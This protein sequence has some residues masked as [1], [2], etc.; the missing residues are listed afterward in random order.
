MQR[1]L[2]LGVSFALVVE[3]GAI[4]SP[5]PETV[6]TQFYEWWVQNQDQGRQR[7]SQQRA[8]FT[9]ELYQQLMQAFRKQPRDG[10]WLDFDPFSFTQV[11]TQ[12]VKV[13]SVRRSPN[14][15]RVAEVDIE[16]MAGLR[17]RS[18]TTVPMKGLLRQGGDRWQI[19]NLIYLNTWDNLRCLLR[20]IN[21]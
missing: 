19:D 1:W 11:R 3:R 15:P 20:D 8:A 2:P 17:G 5:A 14:N 10:T 21:R 13:R 9:S 6:V 18:G 12:G 7:L 4:A 16:V